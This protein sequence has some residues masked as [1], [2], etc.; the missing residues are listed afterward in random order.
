MAKGFDTARTANDAAT[1]SVKTYQRNQRRDTEPITC[2]AVP[3]SQTADPTPNTA[4]VTFANDAT[5]VLV[6]LNQLVIKAAAFRMLSTMS[7]RSEVN[8]LPKLF[9]SA[10]PIE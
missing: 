9:L 6:V 8:A 2:R 10:S 1:W 7:P 5:S 4:S 3:N